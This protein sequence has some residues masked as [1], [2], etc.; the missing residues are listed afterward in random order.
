MTGSS[1]CN[2]IPYWAGKLGK[3]ELFARQLSER[4]GELYCSLAGERVK[5]GGNAVFY[6][7]GEIYV[8]AKTAKSVH[9]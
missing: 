1:H 2:L 4:G 9:V 7:K 6:M 5:I 3:S 8:E